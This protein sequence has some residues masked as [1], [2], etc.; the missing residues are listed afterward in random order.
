MNLECKVKSAV[1]KA[2]VEYIYI[3]ILIGE[4]EIKYFPTNA[5]KELIKLSIQNR[6]ENR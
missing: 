5:E 6:K 2:G 3:S 1:S 4:Y